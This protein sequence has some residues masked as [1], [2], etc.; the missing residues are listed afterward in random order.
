MKSTT[1]ATELLEL[2]LNNVALPLIGDASG[3]LPSAADGN[4]YVALHTADPGAGGNQTTSEAAYTNYNRIPVARDG[5]QWTV[6][7]GV[8]ENA[9]DLSGNICTA[10]SAAVTYVSLGTASSGTGKI[11]YSG[12]LTTPIAISVGINPA[13]PAG[14]L[15]I[16]ES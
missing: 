10:G 15:T 8:G 1:Y 9:F 7:A 4:L 16:S 6:A 5:A 14:D 12:L 13:F 11:L 2:V 3:L